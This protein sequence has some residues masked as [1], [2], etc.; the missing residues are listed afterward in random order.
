MA[1]DIP[2]LERSFLRDV[3][4]AM[5]PV[6]RKQ[7][8]L[9]ALI[10]SQFERLEFQ[11]VELQRRE[12]ELA[13]DRTALAKERA[14]LDEEWAHFDELVETARVH[15]LEVRQERQ[16][17]E[18]L[19]R[20]SNHVEQQA[21]LLRLRDALD[22]VEHE[23]R[24]LLEELSVVQA[25]LVQAADSTSELSR[26]AAEIERLRREADSAAAASES[27]W[28]TKLV[29]IEAER[30]RA[31][32]ELSEARRQT[33]ELARET[34]A[35]RR[36]FA[37]ER[38]E[39]LQEL[40]SMRSSMP[41]AGTRAESPSRAETSAEPALPAAE[42][43]EPDKPTVKSAPDLLDRLEAVQRGAARHRPNRR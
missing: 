18:T 6:R 15:A 30:D 22:L 16:R 32:A 11:A 21:E 40:R 1:P 24:V 5:E 20:Q 3:E 14:S 35:E 17:V 26:A 39:W 27:N 43:P 7:R 4:A 2:V 37:Q 8:D 33:L 36:R 31:V 19:L 42:P 23:K 10:A 34:D 38:G 25:K 9:H 13:D 12:R 29:T 41:V 28:R